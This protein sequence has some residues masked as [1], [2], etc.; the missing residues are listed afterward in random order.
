MKMTAQSNHA[1]RPFTLERLSN[2][3]VIVAFGLVIVGFSV[4]AE[5]FL[6]FENLTNLV[7]NKVVLLAIVSLGMTIVIAS[8]GIDLSVGVSI[9]LSSMAFIMMI[10]AGFSGINGVLVA[11][12]AAIAV[13]LLNAVLINK[14][15]ID[16]FLATLGVLFIGKSIQQLATQGGV[17]IYL[18]REEYSATFEAISRTSLLGVPTPVIVLIVCV[19]AVYIA[20][21]R[22]KFGR[23]LS[24]L[25]A[26]P[27]VAK[28][29][30]IR[31]PF[32]LTMVF[33]S[34]AVLCGIAGI[35]LSSTVRS[36]VP[37]AGD[38]FLLDAIGATFIGTAI[39]AE[40]KPTVLGTILGVLLLAVL[41]NGLLLMGWNFFWQQVG[42]GVLVFVVLGMSFGLRKQA[43]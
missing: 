15:K 42:I 16:P 29:S 39:S 11:I 19:V 2:Y 9:D 7:V 30:G 28:Y 26:Q 32:Q 35:L 4:F 36:Y 10:A 33:V 20:L 13:G 41:R 25:G 31:V 8:G 22:S 14:L 40:R 17:P 21:H 37:L 34:S 23:Y 27:G 6:N 18:T 38:A 3:F 24:A 1:D 43:E 12:C 5:G